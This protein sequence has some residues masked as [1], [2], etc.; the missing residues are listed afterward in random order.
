MKKLTAILLIFILTFSFTGC[1]NTEV[2]DKPVELTDEDM[3][4]I[5]T[6]YDNRDQWDGVWNVY[7]H[8]CYID[9]IMFCDF[10]NTG[11][12]SFFIYVR[13]QGAYDVIGFYVYDGFEQME[14]SVYD[15]DENRRFEGW[16][17]RIAY[18]LGCEY[19]QDA[20]DDAKYESLKNA[21]KNYKEE[22]QK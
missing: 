20:S 18:D 16:E 7:T 1:L 5:D 11:K 14:F 13:S 15:V 10:D 22:N 21:Y 6:V 9:K 2:E 19:D 17:T 4:Y 3:K 8:D 12:I